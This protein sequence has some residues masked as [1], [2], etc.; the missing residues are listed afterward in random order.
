MAGVAKI[1]QVENGVEL[2]AEEWAL[3]GKTASRAA[4]AE[5]WGVS[6][7]T[8][9]NWC[10]RDDVKAAAGKFLRDQVLRSK[11]KID[12]KIAEA[13][14]QLDPVDDFELLLKARKELA[15]DVPRDAE[16]SDEE[17]LQQAF[18]VLDDRPDLA[19]KLQAAQAA[20]AAD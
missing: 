19:K 7:D 2:F 14:E 15:P 11:R 12:A 9:T 8:I 16:M 3:G 18:E 4:L 1:E 17:L 6:K 20:D 5:R 10:K 13:I